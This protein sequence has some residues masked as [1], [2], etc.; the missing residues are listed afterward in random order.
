MVPNENGTIGLFDVSTH[1]F[2]QGT[3]KEWRLMD[4]STGA[5]RQLVEDDK[6]HDV[7]WLPGSVDLVVWLR[8]AEDG[9]TQLVLVDI[10]SPSAF[11]SIIAEFDE[12]S[13]T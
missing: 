1:E 12:R 4:L 8:D 7:N 2:G 5:S 11:S 13:S 9:T 3:R 6:V 10:D